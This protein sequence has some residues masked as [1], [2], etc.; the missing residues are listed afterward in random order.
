MFQA[1]VLLL[2]NE[3]IEYTFKEIQEATKIGKIFF[4]I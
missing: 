2:F 3:R 1:I 4:F